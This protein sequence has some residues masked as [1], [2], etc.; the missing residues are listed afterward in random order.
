[1]SNVICTLPW[2]TLQVDKPNGEAACCCLDRAKISWGNVINDGW[3]NVWNGE[4]AQAHRAAMLQGKIDEYCSHNCPILLSGAKARTGIT[5]IKNRTG[6][7]SNNAMIAYNSID[8]NLLVL[9]NTPIQINLTISYLCNHNCII[10]GQ[11]H[12]DQTQ[13]PW[14][15]L[16]ALKPWF[17]TIEVIGFSGGEPVTSGIFIDF[18]SYLLKQSSEYRPSLGLITNGTL[19]HEGLLN[20]LISIGITYLIV[21][22]HAFSK[23]TYRLLHGKDDYDNVMQTVQL[24]KQKT[25]LQSKV[26]LAFTITPDNVD[27]LQQFAIH[28]GN[29]GLWVYLIPEV[30]G[31]YDNETNQALACK[32]SS[33]LNDLL[34]LD[35]EI[36]ARI[37]GIP[38]C[39][40]YVDRLVKS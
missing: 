29:E 23:E 13:I 18:I 36:K 14:K 22:V 5:D 15:V 19:L 40:E 31:E 37:Y 21:S 28:W 35:N 10:C 17:E 25:E 8:S 1:M 38:F 6:V 3:E 12:S 32:L 16:M 11:N 20:K 33:T 9:K 34:N 27:E 7:T 26:A 24:V 4:K 30:G 39:L 2:T